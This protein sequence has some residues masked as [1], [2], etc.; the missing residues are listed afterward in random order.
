[1]S[2]QYVMVANTPRE[3]STVFAG[4]S[5]YAVRLIKSNRIGFS[6]TTPRTGWRW[7]FCTIR[8]R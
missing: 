3:T 8:C 5:N 4:A 7:E 1:M 6:G 2:W